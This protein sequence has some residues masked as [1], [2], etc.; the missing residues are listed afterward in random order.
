MNKEAFLNFVRQRVANLFQ[1]FP[2]PAHGLNHANRVVG[3]A[4]KI[5][6]EEG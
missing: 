4:K 6:K 3:W 1:D 2:V 5:A